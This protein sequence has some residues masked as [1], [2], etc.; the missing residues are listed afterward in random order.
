MVQE[1]K[2]DDKKDLKGKRIG[3]VFLWALPI[4]VLMV[5]VYYRTLH[6][7]IYY[8]IPLAVAFVWIGYMLSNYI[9]GRQEG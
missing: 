2:D 7:D 5:S 8:E 1:K 6:S 3:N 4:I 9:E